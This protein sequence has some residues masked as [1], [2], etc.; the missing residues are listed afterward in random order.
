MASHGVNKRG[1]GAEPVAKT[2]C[3]IITT[4]VIR[5]SVPKIVSKIFNASSA[6]IMV[7]GRRRLNCWVWMLDF[8]LVNRVCQGRRFHKPHLKSAFL[9]Y[10]ENCVNFFSTNRYNPDLILINPS[11]KVTISGD[12]WKSW[13]KLWKISR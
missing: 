10:K 12:L 6:I 4:I 3:W 13:L 9:V 5:K 1:P 2:D 11:R 7:M 8:A